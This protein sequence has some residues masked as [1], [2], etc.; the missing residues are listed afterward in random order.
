MN[1]FDCYCT[2]CDGSKVDGEAPPFDCVF[3]VLIILAK[4][5]VPAAVEAVKKY[6]ILLN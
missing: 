3:R 5:E 2:E 1:I 6:N 4:L